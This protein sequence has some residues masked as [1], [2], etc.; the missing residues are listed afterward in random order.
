[1]GKQ[2][3]TAPSASNSQEIGLYVCL[4]Q[5]IYLYEAVPH[6]LAPVA[7]GDFR[8]RAGRSAAV[9]APVNIFYVVDLARYVV[10][11]GQPVLRE[12]DP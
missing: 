12:A 2:G 1:M 11:K 4:A 9:K 7:A 8:V 6:R 10:G 5:G 3:R